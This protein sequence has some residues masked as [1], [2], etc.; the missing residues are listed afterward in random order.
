MSS[1]KKKTIKVIQ[2][3]KTELNKN[4]TNRSPPKIFIP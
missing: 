4:R 3:N 2:T 1:Q